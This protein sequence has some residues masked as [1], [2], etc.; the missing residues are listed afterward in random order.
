MREI[1]NNTSSKW[2]CGCEKMQFGRSVDG[3]DV[4]QDD[5]Q[6]FWK[7]VCSRGIE[8]RGARR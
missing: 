4:S 6:I 1:T 2:T 3:V 5:G 7:I 8:E